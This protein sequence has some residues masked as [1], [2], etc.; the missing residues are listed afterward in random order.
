[1]REKKKKANLGT[2]NGGPILVFL[3]PISIGKC[4]YSTLFLNLKRQ[5][6]V[7]GGGQQSFW[8]C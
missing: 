6:S 2:I 3:G 1:M 5:I 7:V 4:L 8:A